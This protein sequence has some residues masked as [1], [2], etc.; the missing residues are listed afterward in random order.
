MWVRECACLFGAFAIFL[1]ASFGYMFG[2]W[3]FVWLYRLRVDHI[4]ILLVAN[5]S[6][7]QQTQWNQSRNVIEMFSIHS[8]WLQYEFIE[9][10]NGHTDICII[11]LSFDVSPFHSIP[12]YAMPFVYNISIR[13]ENV[14]HSISRTHW[15][16]SMFNFDFDF[17]FSTTCTLPRCSVF[18]LP[19][20]VFDLNYFIFH[21]QWRMTKTEVRNGVWL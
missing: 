10:V 5:S 20:S 9:F 21:F 19:W 15:S 7:I 14:C 16:L 6:H 11:R 12:C 1:L 17:D 3:I 13:S 2:L 18:V 8:N 4:R